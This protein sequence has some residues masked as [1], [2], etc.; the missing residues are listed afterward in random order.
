MNLAFKFAQHI[1]RRDTLSKKRDGFVKMSFS[2]RKEEDTRKIVNF[3]NVCLIC[4]TQVDQYSFSLEGHYD[5]LEKKF[6][7]ENEYKSSS[8]TF[9]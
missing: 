1:H 4:L 6:L 5:I 7:E 2:D 9:E 3:E 8:W